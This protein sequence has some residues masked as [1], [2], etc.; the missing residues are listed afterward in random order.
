MTSFAARP[1]LSDLILC[2][3]DPLKPIGQRTRGSYFLRQYFEEDDNNIEIRSKVVETLAEALKDQRHG[4]L[5]RHEFAYIMGQL[6]DIQGCDVLE[7]VLIDTNDDVMVRHECA[8]A[9]GAIGAE[10][11]LPSLQTGSQDSAVEVS[12]T[13]E[14]ALDRL[15]WIEQGSDAA[16]EPMTCACMASPFSSVD[17]APPHPTHVELST[18]ELGSRLLDTDQPLFERYRCMFSLRNR[19]GEECV[20]ALGN[21]LVKDDSSALLRHEVAYVLGQLAHPAAVDS[22]GASLRRNNEHCMVRHESAEALGAIEGRWQETNDLL[23]EFSEDKDQVVR[24]SCLVALDA[25]DYFGLYNK[26]IETDK[27]EAE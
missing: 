4:P 17:P 22:L 21:A 26:N 27:Q 5:M 16:T 20:I 8:E 2:I 14:I 23:K 13:C 6:R 9:L 1:P 25:V 24:E 10:R 3:K 19:G 15:K 7:S 12:E 18:A 11:S